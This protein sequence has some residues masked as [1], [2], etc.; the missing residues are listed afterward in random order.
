[1]RQPTVWY[2]P[3]CAKCRTTRDL[4]RERGIDADYVDYLAQAPTTVELRRVLSLLGTDD[5]R[6][7][8]RTNETLWTEL[9]LDTATDDAIVAA[10]HDHP[11]LIERPIAIAGNR[12]VVARPAERV[13]D[14]LE[15]G[16]D[17]YPTR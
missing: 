9:A 16:T 4:L 17:D 14:L 15:T 6:T 12:A 13:L 3:D 11:A 5:P 8:A 1:M 7:I 2:N 10:L